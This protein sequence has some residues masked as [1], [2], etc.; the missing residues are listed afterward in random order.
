MLVDARL[1]ERREVEA[2]PG[3]EHRFGEGRGL[4][5]VEPLEEAGHEERGHLVIGHVAGGVR[6]DERAPFAGLQ[7]PAVTF[8]LDQPVRQHCYR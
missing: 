4:R 5:A 8:P 7:P 6:H 2:R 3:S 1:A